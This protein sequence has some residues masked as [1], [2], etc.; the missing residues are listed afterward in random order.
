[1][2]RTKNIL[3]QAAFFNRVLR[4]WLSMTLVKDIDQVY[5]AG[6]RAGMRP[7][8]IDRRVDAHFGATTDF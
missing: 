6:R 8:E 4:A 1:M 2:R 5:E 3:Q 7:E